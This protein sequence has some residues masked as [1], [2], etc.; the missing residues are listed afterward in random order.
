M[1]GKGRIALETHTSKA[2]KGNPLGDPHVRQFPVYLPPSYDS[3]TGRYPVVFLLSGFTGWGMMNLNLGFLSESIPQ[4]LDRLISRGKIKEMI[5]VM[6]DCMTKYGGSQYMNSTGTGRYEDYLIKE[7]I[8]YIDS[9]YRTIPRGESRAVC[10]KSSGG[11][12][13]VTL[14]MKHPYLFGLMCSTAGD[15]AF[16]YCYQ[17]DFPKSITGL[18]FYGKGHKAMKRFVTREINP[19]SKKGRN[20]F[21]VL[22]IA[23]MASCYSPNPAAVETKGYNFDLPFDIE[24]G[25]LDQPVFDKWLMNDPVRMAGRYAENLRK[26]KLIYLDAGIYDEYNLH[27]GARIFCSKLKE[28]KVKYVYEEF[29]DTHRNIQYR[30]DRTFEMISS[31]IKA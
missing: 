26:L 12:G 3:G 16:E 20:Y 24:T 2:L 5:V 4:R 28:R 31:K 6:P 21:D 11:Y 9:L 19:L 27:I 1:K 25:E 18:E 17:P 30:Y 8:P 29:P 10:G 15:M 22:N 23:G 13:A 14:A 7:L